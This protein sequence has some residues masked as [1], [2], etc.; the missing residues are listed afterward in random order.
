[1]RFCSEN[2]SCSV[3]VGPNKIVAKIASDLGTLRLTVVEEKTYWDFVPLKAGKLPGV[4]PK[5]ERACWS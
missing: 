4:G 2:L 1:M 3:G 5:T